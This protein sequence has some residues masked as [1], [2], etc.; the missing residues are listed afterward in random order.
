MINHMKKAK[1]FTISDD[2]LAQVAETKGNRSTS[3][4]V[5]DLL[6]EAL[7]LERRERLEQE[8]AEF[9][10]VENQ[11]SNRERESYLKAS[12]KSLSRE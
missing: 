4:R 12:R 3:Q 7:A 11:H 2:I 1:S 5:N 6:R 9:F 10:A 8:A